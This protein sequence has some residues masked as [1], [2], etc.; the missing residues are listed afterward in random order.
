MRQLVACV[1]VVGVVGM[2]CLV[3]AQ[4]RIGIIDDYHSWEGGFS[5]T[6]HKVFNLFPREQ[7]GREMNLLLELIEERKL[8]AVVIKGQISK[9]T[10]PKNLTLKE[11]SDS[12]RR[13]WITEPGYKEEKYEEVDWMGGKAWVHTFTF[14]LVDSYG[15]ARDRFRMK[16]IRYMR[17]GSG[18]WF[19]FYAN[20]QFFEDYVRAWDASLKTLKWD[21]EKPNKDKE[22]G[23]GL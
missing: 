12:G 7:K 21:D 3:S 14:H 19:V 11:W 6:P 13:S 16:S 2:G 22:G 23:G 9:F 5:I 15:K 18:Y 1:G 20:P 17:K 8:P 4:Q 10:N